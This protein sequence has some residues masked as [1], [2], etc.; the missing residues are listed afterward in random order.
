[1]LSHLKIIRAHW[2]KGVCKIREALLEG[3]YYWEGGGEPP[4]MSKSTK[5]F[6]GLKRGKNCEKELSANTV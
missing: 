2:I 5:L 4:E 6:Y 3:F 1:M